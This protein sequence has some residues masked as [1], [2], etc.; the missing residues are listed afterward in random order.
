MN[1]RRMKKKSAI[2]WI[3]DIEY[4]KIL[5]WNPFFI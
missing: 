4:H 1:L 3:E 5:D 2:D